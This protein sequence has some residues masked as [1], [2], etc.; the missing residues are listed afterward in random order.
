M[1]H[2][3]LITGGVRSGKSRTALEIG[4]RIEGRKAFIATSPVVD[5]EMARRIEKHMSERAKLS[6][7]TVEEPLD[8]AGALLSTAHFQVRIVDCLT[9]WINNLM[10]EF[11]GCSQHL[12]EMVI[13]ER[14][15]G[16]VRA[17]S[18]LTGS[19]IF[20]TNEVGMGIVPN[21]EEARR[22]RDFAGKCNQEV[23]KAAN[24]VLFMVSGIPLRLTKG[25]FA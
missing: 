18:E 2:V 6:W 7:E 20:V 13:Q 10:Y 25:D 12:D 23:A 11:H 1:A 8:L 22:F 21:N 9:L 4:Q 19:V 3:T 16:V 14:T 5:K 15:E 24:H 17:C